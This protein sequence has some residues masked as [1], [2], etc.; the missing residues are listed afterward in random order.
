MGI[1]TRSDNN[2]ENI[3]PPVLFSL[4]TKKCIIFTVTAHIRLCQII[5]YEDR[6]QI[7]NA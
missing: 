4:Q 2:N 1:V 6:N 5:I 3:I 7:F